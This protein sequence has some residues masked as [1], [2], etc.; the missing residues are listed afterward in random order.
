MLI[1][2]GIPTEM[3]AFEIPIVEG[4][5]EGWK[6]KVLYN[7]LGE[8]RN[9]KNTIRYSPAARERSFLQVTPDGHMPI[10]IFEGLTQSKTTHMHYKIFYQN[11][12]NFCQMRTG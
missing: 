4:I 11:V 6:N 3:I 1:L 7:I 5:L 9:D 2:F 10:V 8:N 12:Q